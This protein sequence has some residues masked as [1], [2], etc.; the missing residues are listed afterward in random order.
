MWCSASFPFF[1]AR[2]VF[3]A[4]YNPFRL[5]GGVLCIFSPT[6]HL[7]SLSLPCLS[8]FFPLLYAWGVKVLGLGLLY[9]SCLEGWLVMGDDLVALGGDL[10]AGCCGG[11]EG[12]APIMCQSLQGLNIMV[13]V[14]S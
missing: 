5:C 1:I 2:A 11:G 4:F 14:L 13:Y 8:T 6:P 9:L 3:Q 12:S 10:G 7:F